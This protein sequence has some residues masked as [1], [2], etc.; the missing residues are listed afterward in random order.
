MG[1]SA[2]LFRLILHPRWSDKGFHTHDEGD[3]AKWLDVCVVQSIFGGPTLPC[4]WIEVHG[5]TAHLKN[6]TIGHVVGSEF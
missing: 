6:E 1:R 4:D 5:R 2:C 3:N